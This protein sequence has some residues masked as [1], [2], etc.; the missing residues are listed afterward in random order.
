MADVNNPNQRTDFASTTLQ[1]TSD[2]HV[3]SNSQQNTNQPNTPGDVKAH[4]FIVNEQH[5][6]YTSKESYFEKQDAINDPCCLIQENH[7]KSLKNRICFYLQ[8]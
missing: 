8:S 3:H 5:N 1:F 7:L 6:D 4:S 2:Y